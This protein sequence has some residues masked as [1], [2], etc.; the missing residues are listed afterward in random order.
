MTNRSKDRR[1]VRATNAPHERQSSPHEGEKLEP[2]EGKAWAEKGNTCSLTPWGCRGK[3]T[4]VSVNGRSCVASPCLPVVPG[5][6][7]RVWVLQVVWFRRLGFLA[8]PSSFGVSLFLG[9]RHF[10]VG[11]V[12]KTGEAFSGIPVF[13]LFCTGTLSRLTV[14]THTIYAHLGSSRNDGCVR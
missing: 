8:V 4:L 1:V 2:H 10:C 3:E 7:G 9:V 12:P 14:R 13:H 5:F 6:P 11:T